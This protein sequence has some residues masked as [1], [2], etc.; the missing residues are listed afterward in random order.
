MH[1]ENQQV[2]F[3][4]SLASSQAS[5]EFDDMSS[6]T[7]SHDLRS[8]RVSSIDS[9]T[10]K[11]LCKSGRHFSLVLHMAE[12]YRKV[13]FTTYEQMAIGVE[14]L[15]KRGQNLAKRIDQYQ[16]KANLPYCVLVNKYLV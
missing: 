13:Y 3:V 4:M 8:V 2:T 6:E 10:Q 14:Y 9:P 15:L 16:F 12:G 1:V 5:N 11:Y 7:I